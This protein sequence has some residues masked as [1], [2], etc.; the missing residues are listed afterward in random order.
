MPS[1]LLAITDWDRLGAGLLSLLLCMVAF[2]VALF[3]IIALGRLWRRM[4]RAP[5]ARS[6]QAVIVIMFLLAAGLMIGVPHTSFDWK[7]ERDM[8]A[9]QSHCFGITSW[10]VRAETNN[11]RLVT[12]LGVRPNRGIATT[13]SIHIVGILALLPS[14]AA[15]WLLARWQWRNLPG[16]YRRP[17]GRCDVCDYDLRGHHSPVCPE[18]GEPVT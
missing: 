11:A 3:V 7:Y 5:R 14:L 18:C 13:T 10:L 4:T 15:I 17:D 16:F 9:T 8:F 12:L 1:L 2:I 6:M